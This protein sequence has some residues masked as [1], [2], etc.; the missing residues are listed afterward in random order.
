VISTSRRRSASVDGQRRHEHD[1]V[2][3]RAD[4]RPARRARRACTWWP[5]R[6]SSGK[7]AQLDADHEAALAH[8]RDRGQRRRLARSSSSPSSSIFGCRRRAC[9]SLLEDVER[10]ERGA[11]A[12]GLPVYVWPWKNVRNSSKRPRKPS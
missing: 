2:A 6:A 8:L 9:R 4:D 10:R 3:E 11:Q 5:I 12:S 1:D 7:L